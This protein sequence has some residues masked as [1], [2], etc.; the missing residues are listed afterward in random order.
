[1]QR[2]PRNESP[3]RGTPAHP[4]TPHF[5]A[6]PDRAPVA[7]RTEERACRY[8]GRLA[9]RTATRRANRGA[10]DGSG[11]SR[12]ES[13]GGSM[14]EDGLCKTCASL[15]GRSSARLERQVVALEVGGSSPLGHPKFEHR[16]VLGECEGRSPM[17]RPSNAPLAQWQSNGLLIRRFWVR[18]PGGAPRKAWSDTCVACPRPP[19]VCSCWLQFVG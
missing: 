16:Q 2:L 12:N 18:I 9:L 11:E 1:V 17:L 5:P 13:P 15:G 4:G 14:P 7:R 10:L 3:T 8:P 19:F 6:A